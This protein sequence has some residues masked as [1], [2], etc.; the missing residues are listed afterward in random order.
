V[1]MLQ[2]AGAINVTGGALRGVQL[3]GFNNTVLD[4]M[5]GLQAAGFV[6]MVVGNMHGVQLA[7]L[8]NIV[9]HEVQGV[10]AAGTGNVAWMNVRGLQVSP[11]FNVATKEMN[12]LQLSAGVN[13]AHKLKGVQV[14]IVNIADTSDGY[15]LGL[16]NIIHKGYHKLVISSNEIL[17]ISL[18]Y[19]AGN[20][21]LYSILSVGLQPDSNRTIFSVG[22]G[23]GSDI[24]LGK[25]WFFNPEI[26]THYL[27]LNNDNGTHVLNRLQLH[28]SWH[29]HKKFALF[30]GPS[31]S[32]YY[33]S[34][35]NTEGSNHFIPTTGYP[36]F[37]LWNKQWQG[38]I[39]WNAGIT[40]F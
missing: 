36:S 30:A 27:Y 17:P 29:A 2:A 40:I 39:G 21:K 10:Q 12:G 5:R 35:D 20:R 13:Y 22:Y 31:L 34:A 8:V 24:A 18:G 9:A 3:A 1:H 15:S 32:A 37:G 19:K 28:I 6:N 14:G 26:S 38:W 16:I 33:A 4:S 7:G 11:N 23:A 25:K